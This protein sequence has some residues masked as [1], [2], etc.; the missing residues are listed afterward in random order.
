M[1]LDEA[2]AVEPMLSRIF[3]VFPGVYNNT[4]QVELETT[5][6]SDEPHA[7]LKAEVTLLPNERFSRCSFLVRGFL[8]SADL[9]YMSRVYEFVRCQDSV[10]LKVHY[11]DDEPS[12]KLPSVPAGVRSALKP[13]D[14]SYFPGCDLTIA[15]EGGMLVGRTD[16]ATS[17]KTVNGVANVREHYA[18]AIDDEEI[19]IWRRCVAPDGAIL[20][21]RADNLPY[22]LE[23]Q[24]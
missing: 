24:N 23:R 20:L 13:S 16:S 9:P 4:R 8:G 12:L 3:K 11:F 5:Q 19:K 10:L 1:T 17:I 7:L 6:S 2:H 14:A 21:G 15:P 18:L 22:R